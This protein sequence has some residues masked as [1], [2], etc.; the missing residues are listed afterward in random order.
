[1]RRKWPDISQQ[2][3]ST[4]TTNILFIHIIPNLKRIGILKLITTIYWIFDC[5]YVVSFPDD[6]YCT[7]Q[8]QYFLHNVF[9]RSY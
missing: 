6:P 5:Y 4:S 9:I 1:M 8:I 2:L 3:E 7:I